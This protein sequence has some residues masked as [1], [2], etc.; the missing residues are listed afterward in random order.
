LL[1]TEA[2]DAAPLVSIAAPDHGVT[3]ENIDES[4]EQRSRFDGIE[5]D[6]TALTPNV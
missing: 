1:T 6:W 3:T 5:L 2:A 4:Q